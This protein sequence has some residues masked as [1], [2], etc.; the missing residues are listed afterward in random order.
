MGILY[1][2]HCIDKRRRRKKWSEKSY[3]ALGCAE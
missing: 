2:E 3:L 1:R